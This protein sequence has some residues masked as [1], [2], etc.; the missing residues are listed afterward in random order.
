MAYPAQKT[1]IHLITNPILIIMVFLLN[2]VS[3]MKAKDD[4]L[5]EHFCRESRQSNDK[6]T[7]NSV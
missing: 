7:L 3:A 6:C 1:R 2:D 5:F 4:W